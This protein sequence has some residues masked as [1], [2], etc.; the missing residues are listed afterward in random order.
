MFSILAARN[1]DQFYNT[2][3]GSSEIS[4]TG[5]PLAFFPR[6]LNGKPTFVVVFPVCKQ[7]SFEHLTKPVLVWSA[8]SSTLCC[9]PA[10]CMMSLR[11]FC[12]SKK[13]PFL[14]TTSSFYKPRSST[15]KKSH[16]PANQT[17][18]LSSV[19]PP[20]FVWNNSTIMKI[21]QVF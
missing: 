14:S 4:P 19:H 15:T 21:S 5:F 11:C 8:N 1:E 10:A 18:R 20:S 3:D 12:A 7:L 16:E 6:K 13:T 2:S 17:S 9:D